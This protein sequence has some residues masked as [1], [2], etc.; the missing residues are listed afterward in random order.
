MKQVYKR[1]IRYR[2]FILIALMVLPF[3]LYR[4]TNPLVDT[5]NFRQA[6]TA[7]V[8]RNFYRQGINLGL[9]ELDIFG[10]GKEKYLLL[11][12]PL[13]QA[14][15]TIL[16][17]TFFFNEIW[18]RI[19]SIVAGLVGAYYL[20]K[21]VGLT[22]RDKKLRLFSALFFLFVPLN[23]YYQRTFLIETTVIAFMLAG[24]YYFCLW[25][26]TKRWLYFFIT[27]ILF[28]FGFLQKGVYGPFWLLPLSV[29]YL[30]KHSW[31]NRSFIKFILILAIPLFSLYLWQN[32]VNRINIL[33]GQQY[34][35]TVDKG[36]MLWNF[37]NL[38]DRLSWSMWHERLKYLLNGIFL[39]PGILFFFLGAIGIIKYGNWLFFFSFVLTAFLYFVTLFRIQSHNYYQM[40]MVPPLVVFIAKGF[41]MFSG[42]ITR[43]I[44]NKQKIISSRLIRPAIYTLIFT[45]FVW[46]SFSFSRWS[47]AADLDW[48][49][50]LIA[51]GKSVPK[52]SYGILV[53]YGYDWNSIYTYY[54]DRKMILV[55][56]KQLTEAD[57]ILWQKEGYSFIIF[58]DFHKYQDLYGKAEFLKAYKYAEKY[59]L[60]YR[61]DDF[62]VYL[63]K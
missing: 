62:M 55:D 61:S 20:Y 47:F 7:T 18:G 9:S 60:V 3:R 30:K 45:L 32:H 8:A 22:T 49:Q 41:M 11:E 16:Y 26:D 38:A 52:N 23:L 35:T 29:Y 40:I 44:T 27:I 54:P 51:V 5:P 56:S 59:P 24:V 19:V 28:T 37:G 53:N 4:I 25:T 48:Y 10:I 43:L 17:R 2:F 39:K 42:F 34:F 31:R 14:L 12:F 36:H 63:F 21:I 50:R 46:R 15:V 13:Y 33:S 58:H 6:Q 57:I 1:F